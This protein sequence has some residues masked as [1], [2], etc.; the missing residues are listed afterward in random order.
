MP[1]EVVNLEES[2]ETLELSPTHE[3]IWKFIDQLRGILLG[4]LEAGITNPTQLAAMK[5]SVTREVYRCR[6]EMCKRIE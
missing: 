4:I 5:K 1:E 6:I 2:K 3:V